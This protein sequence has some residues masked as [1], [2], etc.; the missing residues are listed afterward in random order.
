MKRS[1]LGLSVFAASA[2]MLAAL[3]AAGQQKSGQET[4]AQEERIKPL[5]VGDAAPALKV[6]KWV[7]GAPVPS[8]EKGKV[9]VVEGWA[10][11][12]PPCRESIPHLT[13]LAKKYKDKAVIIGV[14]VW[15]NDEAYTRKVEEFVTKMGD[16]ME[17]SVAIDTAHDSNGHVA[18]NWLQAAGLN[19]IPA[20]FIVNGEGRVAWIGHPMSMDKPLEQIV[21]GTWD[22][23]A[24]VKDYAKKAEE[25]ARE[26]AEREKQMAEIR[27]IMDAIR[28][29]DYAAANRGYDALIAKYPDRAV[30]LKMDR[31]NR[32]LVGDPASSYAT[33]RDLA[34]HEFKNNAMGLNALAW[35]I[36]DHPKLQNPDFDLAI[37]LAERAVE[38]TNSKDGMVMDT[39]AVAHFKKG[40][41][42]KAIE[43][44]TKAIALVGDMDADTA[45]EL[46]QRLEEFKAAKK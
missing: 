10:T 27:P 28:E 3:P 8:F 7:K 36:V 35:T 26:Q 11:W 34:A 30:Q 6:G 29:K 43:L 12:C 40:H 2:V 44:Q 45:A 18:R 25:A 46:K 41:V 17:Y 32:M 1:L 22:M 31:F 9:Y 16:K 13:E 37:S 38:L 33:A 15:E 5:G 42:D 39:L 23:D 21:G 19:G 14:S 24:A 4:T 20:S